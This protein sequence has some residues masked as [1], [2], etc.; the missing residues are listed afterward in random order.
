LLSG[1]TWFAPSDVTVGPDGA[2]YI[3]D[4][5][6]QRTA[7]PDPDAEWDRTNGRIYRI[8]AKGAPRR[9]TAQLTSQTSDKL[10]GMLSNTNDWY[11]RKARRLLADRR[12]PEVILPLRTLVMEST[13]EHTAL[14]ALWA[15]YVSGGLSEEFAWRL[16]D[17]SSADIRWWTVRL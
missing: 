15:L 5:H 6:D 17:H 7:H 8:G 2:I 9:A 12:D 11:V 14:E 1:D 13:D 3:C 4:W 10:V 16:L